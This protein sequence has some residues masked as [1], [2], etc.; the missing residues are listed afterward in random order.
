MTR[1]SI[2]TSHDYMIHETAPDY[3]DPLKA[4]SWDIEPCIYQGTAVCTHP[5]TKFTAVVAAE[6][7]FLALSHH[8]DGKK[9]PPAVVC[10]ANT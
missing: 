2:S 10:L 5:G 8:Q 6:I 1:S 4:I 3:L 9:L 7:A